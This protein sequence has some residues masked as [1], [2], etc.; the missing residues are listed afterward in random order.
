MWEAVWDETAKDYYYWN[1]ETDET[2][3]TKPESLKASS[4][5]TLKA[6]DPNEVSEEKDIKSPENLKEAGG[7][8]YYN[9]KEYYE[10]YT[11]AM[12]EYQI[13]QS[14]TATAASYA[15]SQKGDRFAELASLGISGVDNTSAVAS[16]EFKQMSYY[17]DV[18]KYQQERALDR[19]QPKVTKK[20][21]KKE[22]DKFKKQKHERKVASLL[23]RM[24]PDE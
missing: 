19:L 12:A 7:D 16:R 4:K 18:D 14:A 17:F 6:K 8:D 21:T 2:T 22:I 24:G 20:Y 5:D 9:S 13:Q 3:W 11:K 10:W 23:Q 1:K 15:A